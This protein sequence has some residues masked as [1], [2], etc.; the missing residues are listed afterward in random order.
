MKDASIFVNM[1]LGQLW[2]KF[3]FKAFV[4]LLMYIAYKVELLV[5]NKL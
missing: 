4:W 3:L 2:I 1:Y 5:S